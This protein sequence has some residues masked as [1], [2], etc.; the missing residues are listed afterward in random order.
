MWPPTSAS[1]G[2]SR[3][4]L[5]LIE[6]RKVS[7]SAIQRQVHGTH[8][9]G[10]GLSGSASARRRS[11]RRWNSAGSSSPSRVKATPGKDSSAGHSSTPLYRSSPPA[12]NSSTA[13]RKERWKRRCGGASS[14]MATTVAPGAAA[15]QRTSELRDDRVQHGLGELAG[16][17]VLL[18][19]VVAAQE[20][21]LPTRAGSQERRGAVPEPRLGPR[22]LPADPP[23][24]RQRGI[25]ADRAERQHRA[26]PRGRELE[27]PVE[28]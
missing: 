24:A 8:P 11:T 28:P 6:P 10:R 19:D 2:L 4:C 7:A 13:S 16:E 23:R 21:D 25:P 5:R 20:P 12:R 27:L 1:I 22:R 9:L 18:A 15:I 14:T 3:L 26:Q 17:G